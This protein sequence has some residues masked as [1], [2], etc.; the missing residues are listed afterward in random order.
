MFI[1]S[2][3]TNHRIP[4]T[5]TDV[6]TKTAKKVHRYQVIPV[7]H[8]IQ[9]DYLKPI[10]FTSSIP[11]SRCTSHSFLRTVSQ[12]SEW[13]TGNL[14]NGTLRRPSQFV[15]GSLLMSLVKVGQCLVSESDRVSVC[16]CVCV[17]ECVWWEGCERRQ[18]RRRWA[19]ESSPHVNWTISPITAKSLLTAGSDTASRKLRRWGILSRCSR[20]V[21]LSKPPVCIAV[22][23]HAAHV[24]VHGWGSS[25]MNESSKGGEKQFEI[26]Q[27]TKRQSSIVHSLVNYWGKHSEWI[28]SWAQT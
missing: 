14:D 21:S 22:Q 3:F 16:V 5:E 19:L 10:W 25:L 28:A 2:K 15:R 24:N 13:F 7:R 12:K 20:T 9:T 6:S 17:C 26:C 4:E 18:M 11:I 23:G 8:P 27:A 1:R